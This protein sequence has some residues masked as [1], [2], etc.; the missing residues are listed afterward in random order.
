MSGAKVILFCVMA[1]YFGDYFYFLGPIFAFS[2]R[3]NALTGRSDK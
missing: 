3:L 1:S 2:K